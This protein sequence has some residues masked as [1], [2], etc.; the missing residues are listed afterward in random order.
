MPPLISREE[1]L[2]LGE[3]E[4]RAE[5]EDRIPG[6]RRRNPTDPVSSPI[7]ARSGSGLETDRPGGP[8]SDQKEV[9]GV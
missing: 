2:R 3:L 5:I 6:R 7:P 1:A 9:A 8:K 4:D